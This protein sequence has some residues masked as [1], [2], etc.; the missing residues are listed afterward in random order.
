MALAKAGGMTANGAAALAY[1]QAKAQANTA[2]DRLTSTLTGHLLQT[3]QAAQNYLGLDYKMREDRADNQGGLAD[4]L[5][6]LGGGL[7]AK[8]L[9]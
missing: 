9:M 1:N 5:L 4:Q 6:G 2:Q 3:E 7:L 8:F